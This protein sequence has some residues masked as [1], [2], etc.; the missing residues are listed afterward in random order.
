MDNASSSQPLTVSETIQGF[1]NAGMGRIVQLKKPLSTSEAVQIV[2]QHLSLKHGAFVPAVNSIRRS[3][4]LVQLAVPTEEKP[5]RSIAVCAGSG[6]C[7]ISLADHPTSSADP[8]QA[9]A[10]FVA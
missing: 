7:T 9:Q 2:K 8:V 10:C 6:T 5:I 1:E 3:Y 4:T